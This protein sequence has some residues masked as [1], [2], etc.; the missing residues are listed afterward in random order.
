[1]N[2]PHAN[3]LSRDLDRQARRT[4]KTRLGW[5]THATVYLAVIGGLSLLAYAN[6]RHLPVGVALGWGLGLTIH[7]LRVLLTG[8][9]L[10]ERMVEAERER[11]ATRRQHPAAGGA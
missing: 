5:L 9:G 7:G 1:M 6:G 2:T 4:V 3:D 10:R 11:I 8:S